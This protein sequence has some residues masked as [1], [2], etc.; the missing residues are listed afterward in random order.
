MAEFAS[1][2]F[3]DREFETPQAK[4]R[5]FQWLTLEER[6][7]YLC[8]VTDMILENAP[9]L[10]ERKYAEPVAGHIRVVQA[11]GCEYVVIGGIAAVLHGVPGATF[12]L[13]I[14]IEAS[15]ENSRRVLEA[16]SRKASQNS[17]ASAQTS[18]A[19]R[20]SDFLGGLIAA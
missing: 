9:R 16:L 3:H 2:V 17:G 8:A 12:D 4:A 1:G 10:A 15:L 6:M 18:A 11:H 7:E 14:L 20:L 5:W 13:D 19:F